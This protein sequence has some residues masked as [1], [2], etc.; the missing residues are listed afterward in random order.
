VRGNE[1]I[2]TGGIAGVH[3]GIQG[4]PLFSNKFKLFLLTPAVEIEGFYLGSHLSGILSNP[5]LE[6]AI[7]RSEG[8]VSVSHSVQPNIHVFN[9]T[10]ALNTGNVFANI[11]VNFDFLKKSIFSPY[12]GV[13]IG[14]AINR[15]SGANSDQIAP[16]NEDVNHF[17]TAR[18][19]N[20]TVLATQ[21]KL[22]LE[23]IFFEKLAIFAEYRYLSI[24]ASSYTFGNT[25]YPGHHPNTS[26][27]ELNLNAMN[28]QTGVFGIRY[29]LNTQ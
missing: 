29:F 27:W 6:P 14:L 24:A 7:L 2:Q 20:N 13:G 3:I 10:F 26:K 8:S 19:A 12:A 21:V 25:Y 5:N 4:T 23:K 1:A 22:G 11:I 18:S 15:L 17:N 16:Y 9:D 28:F